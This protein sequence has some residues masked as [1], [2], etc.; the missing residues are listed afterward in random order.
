MKNKALQPFETMKTDSNASH[1]MGYFYVFGIGALIGVVSFV[2]SMAAIPSDIS[3][4]S[5]HDLML[6]NNLGFIYPPIIGFWCGFVRRSLRWMLLGITVG[7]VLGTLYKLLCGYNY[8]LVMVAFPCVLGGLAS[9]LLGQEKRPYVERSIL[10]FLKG[11]VAG[12]VLGLVYMVILNALGMIILPIFN[13]STAQYREMMWYA[14]TI[15]MTVASGLHLL[16]F[17]WSS[18]LC[19]LNQITK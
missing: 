10:R 18:E 15:A 7:L 2:L 19:P 16:L 4:A 1:L 8:L 5:I 3:N 14:G 9:S 12:F 13:P 6:A 11:L 17:H